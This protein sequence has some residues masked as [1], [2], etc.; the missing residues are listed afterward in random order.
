MG[1][2]LLKSCAKALNRINSFG[3]PPG[4]KLSCRERKDGVKL[5]QGHAM[6]VSES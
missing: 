5:L 1:V 6:M 2:K 4:G 3:G